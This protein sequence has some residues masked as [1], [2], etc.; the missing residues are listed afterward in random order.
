MSNEQ[1]KAK[2]S[3]RRFQDETAVK[4]QVKIAKQRGTFDNAH[5][6]VRQP[7][8]LVK[9]HAMDCGNPQCGM[10][11]NPRHIRKGVDGGLTPQERRLF[12]D[13]DNTNDKHSNGLPPVDE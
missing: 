4:K 2:N 9:R 13:L 8:R 7:H 12:Q 6:V 3:L 5:D 11:G 1:S 10:C